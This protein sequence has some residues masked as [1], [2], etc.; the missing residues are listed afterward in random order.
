[1]EQILFFSLGVVTV[2]ALALVVGAVRLQKQVV[3]LQREILNLQRHLENQDHYSNDRFRETEE[4]SSAIDRR[5]DFECDSIYRAMDS[6]FDKLENKL[7][8]KK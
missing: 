6:R 2:I 8:T 5:I 4:R 7:T 1:M 3:N